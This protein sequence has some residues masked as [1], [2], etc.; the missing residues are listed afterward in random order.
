[1]TVH[2]CH[3]EGGVIGMWYEENIT[4]EISPDL[5]RPLSA[6]GRTTEQTSRENAAAGAVPISPHLPGGRG[7][8]V[9]PDSA[10]DSAQLVEERPWM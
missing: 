10:H 7:G 9:S 3:G 6:F 1:M 2:Q 8:T 4:E 5:A